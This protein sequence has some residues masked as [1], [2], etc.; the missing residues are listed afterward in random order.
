MIETPLPRI[1]HW[2]DVQQLIDMNALTPAEH[3]LI[4]AVKQGKWAEIGSAVPHSKTVSVTM[5]APLLQYLIKGGCN[6]FDAAGTG[7]QVEGA[8]IV[9]KV[10][11]NFASAVGSIALV[12]CHIEERPRMLQ[13]KAPSLLF[14][15]STLA[16]GLNAQGADVVGDVV[17]EG[18]TVEGELCLSGANIGG[19]LICTKAQLLHGTGNALNVQGAKIDGDVFLRGANVEG[20]VLLSGAEV[21]GQ[22]SFKDARLRN[23]HG[24]AVDMQRTVV[25]EGFYWQQVENVM[26]RVDLTSAHLADL[27]DDAESWDKC[28][29]LCLVGLTYDVLHGSADVDQRL[30]W[31]EKGAVWDGE[32]H[33]QPYEQLAK[34]LRESGHRTEATSIL[35]D[36]ELARRK[37][38]RGRWWEDRKPFRWFLQLCWDY[39][40][41]FTIGFGHR[42]QRS[43]YVLVVLVSVAW[44]FAHFA[45]KEGDF[46]PNVAVL[47]ISEDWQ[48]LAQGPDAVPNPAMVW[49]DSDHAGKDYETFHSVAYAVDVV[50]PLVSLGQDAAWAPSTNR[51]P[52]GW[53]LWWLRWV[54]TVL[55]WIVTAIGAA[56]VTGVIRKD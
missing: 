26:G 45:W 43:F 51:G 21:G 56:A 7:V 35:F 36:K 37:A 31:L 28:D 1:A 53:H 19:Q 13:I 55:G 34:V 22:L 12:N 23:A 2:A 42:P 10:D 15:G 47:L 52:W 16:K 33:P 49:G 41:Q 11:L 29:E 20:G 8:W 38:I 24:Y 6:E 39:M 3:Q 25:K 44:L 32:F 50:V 30:V 5:R 40:L 14:K 4:E 46:A 54:L 48:A 17:V 9:G 27:A 18:T